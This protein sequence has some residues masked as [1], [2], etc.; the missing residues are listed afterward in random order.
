MAV[1][2]ACPDA[3]T[4]V[5]AE[6]VAE[7]PV[8]EFNVK[9]TTPPFTGS[10]AFLAVTVTASGFANACVT[11]GRLR[12]AAATGVRLKPWLWKAPMST[13]PGP[14]WPRWSWPGAPAE[15]PGAD[16]RAAGEQRH[17]RRR[18]AVVAQGRQSG[19]PPI[20]LLVPDIAGTGYEVGVATPAE[21]PATIVLVINEIGNAQRYR[22]RIPR[23]CH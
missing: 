5:P 13:W 3:M 18:A 9:V 1:T 11:A 16:R 15:R 23:S 17:S 19:L 14:R 22:R 8:P 10:T 6:S 4:A 21:L 20:R 12:G 7:A 2:A